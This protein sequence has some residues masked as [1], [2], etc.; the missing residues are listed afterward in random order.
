MSTRGLRANSVGGYLIF[1][2][3]FQ[4]TV[5]HSAQHHPMPTKIL[6][7]VAKKKK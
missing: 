2:L 1:P 5:P 4:D 6:S 7:C 3:L